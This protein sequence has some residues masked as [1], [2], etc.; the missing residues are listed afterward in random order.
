MKYLD[1]IKMIKADGWYIER[2]TGSHIQFRHPKKE[3]TMTISAGGKIGKD[4]P[5]S[6][7]V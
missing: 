4:V 6:R 1:V 3:G 5:L 7:R 2:T